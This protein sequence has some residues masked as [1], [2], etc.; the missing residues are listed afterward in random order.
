MSIVG[1]GSDI[2]RNDKEEVIEQTDYWICRNNWGTDWGLLGYFKIKIGIPECKLEENVSACSPYLYERRKGQDDVIEGML[3]GK[4]INILDME[5]INAKLWKNRN[6]LKINFK[7]F[8][9]D[10]TVALIKKGELS[11]SLTPLIEYPELLPDMS[12]FWVSD[13][14]DYDYQDMVDDLGADKKDETHNTGSG[15]FYATLLASAA[16]IGF[17]GY[18]S[19][20]PL[21]ESKQ[22]FNR[23]EK[24]SRLY[25]NA[26]CAIIVM[27]I[28]GY[29]VGY[30][31]R[32]G[33]E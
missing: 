21:T 23:D 1:Y 29:I 11:G 19:N 30:R 6:Y 22:I 33:E 31:I 17:L 10:E 7:M 14:L 20:M 8:Y 32:R 28:L 12:Q 9:T 3:N 16:V 27:A 26:L 18:M 24:C 25:F 15:A 5:K 2:K 13:I 4:E